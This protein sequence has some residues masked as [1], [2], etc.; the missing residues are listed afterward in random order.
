[1]DRIEPSKKT[2]WL[3]GFGVFFGLG[4]LL[5][6]G[7][8]SGDSPVQPIRYNHAVH[9]ANGLACEDCHVGART[10]EKATLPGVDTCLSCHKDPLTKSAEEEKVRAFA[11]ASQEIPW[12]QVTRVPR[13]VYFSHRRHVALAGMKCSECHGLMEVRTEP[14]ARPFRPMTMKACIECHQQRKARYDCNDCHR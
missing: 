1:M 10:S 14:P 3:L 11:R 5:F 2:S 6:R 12:V 13:H 7:V 9:I 4:F 8:L